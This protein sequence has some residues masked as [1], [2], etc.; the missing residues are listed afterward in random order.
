MHGL[1]PCTG[2]GPAPIQCLDPVHDAPEIFADRQIAA[3]QFL[4]HAQ[5]VLSIE[6]QMV[7]MLTE[8][9]INRR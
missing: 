4:Q 9:E 6:T 7:E 2:D 1:R 8:T 3:A 5:A